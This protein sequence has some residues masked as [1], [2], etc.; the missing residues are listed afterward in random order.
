MQKKFYNLIYSPIILC[1]AVLVVFQNCESNSSKKNTEKN[2]W[3]QVKLHDSLWIHYPPYL[4]AT[5][6]ISKEAIWQF[7]SVDSFA[8]VIIYQEKLPRLDSTLQD[9]FLNR[10]KQN[11]LSQFPYSIKQST[12]YSHDSSEIK[13]FSAVQYLSDT[14]IISH[15]ISFIEEDSIL[16]M[17]LTQ[18]KS[19]SLFQ[20]NV[21]RVHKYKQNSADSTQVNL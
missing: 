11:W 12:V 14:F 10:C 3:K 4:T 8:R 19:G 1:L 16:Y 9:S 5:Y 7:H 6:A 2:N 15:H 20:E 17:L 21:F 13:V 18:S